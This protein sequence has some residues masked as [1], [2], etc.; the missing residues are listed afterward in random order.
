M[1]CIKWSQIELRW[2]PRRHYLVTRAD[3]SQI[4]I[5]TSVTGVAKGVGSSDGLIF[6][7][8]N[9]A[10]EHLKANPGDYKGAKFAHKDHLKE[11]GAFG[12]I[13]HESIEDRL[14]K[15][16]ARHVVTGPDVDKALDHWFKWYRKEKF[17]E[18][19][20]VEQQVACFAGPI[21]YAGTFDALFLDP[22]GKYVLADWKTSKSF[23]VKYM[24]QAGAYSLALR[25]EY[26]VNVDRF[27]CLRMGRDGSCE[28]AAT[29]RMARLEQIFLAELTNYSNYKNLETWWSHQKKQARK[30]KKEEEKSENQ[31]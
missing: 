20:A 7:A 12:D 18:V 10:F 30:K 23:N 11:A 13:V 15:Q 19:V 4:E 22:E 17:K 28:I 9:H 24:S 29:N 6:W 31:D 27:V 14:L 25:T 16:Q 26:G 2:K 21:P 8:L 3:G 1:T 5:N